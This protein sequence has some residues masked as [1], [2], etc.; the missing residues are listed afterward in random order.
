MGR[1]LATSRVKFIDYTNAELG[2]DKSNYKIT[3]DTI[4]ALPTFLITRI[5]CTDLIRRDGNLRS[6]NLFSAQIG[7]VNCRR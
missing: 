1:T 7:R 3:M 4:V 2:R 6:G 5:H